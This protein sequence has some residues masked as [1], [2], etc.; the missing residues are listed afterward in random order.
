MG[1]HSQAFRNA[2]HVPLQ[3]PASG[4]VVQVLTGGDSYISGWGSAAGM[5]DAPVDGKLYGRRDG[6]WGIVV[7]QSYIDAQLALKLDKT[8]YTAADVF[9]K[10]LTLD[11]VG[12]ALDAD[13]LD[14]QHGAFYLARAN[15]TGTQA[16]ST[17]TNLQSELDAKELAANKGVA[18]GYAPLD[19][20]AKIA[21]TYLPAYVDDVLE[22]ASLAAFPATGVAGVI[23]VALDTKKIYRWSGSAY[24]ELSP[25]PGSTDAVPEGSV[26]LYFTTG[27]AAAAAPVQTV[28]GR[29]GAVVITKSDL[30]L[31]QVDN[32]SDANKPIST[33][34]ANALALKAPLASPTFTGTPNA[35]TPSPGDSTT[36]LATTAFVAAAVAAVGGISPSDT[37]PA[38]DGSG[39]A[40]V[41]ALYSR[42]DHVH[43]S[44]T[45]RAPLASPT[46]TGTPAAPTAAT[47]TN[48]TQIATTAFVKNQGY[49][50]VASFDAIDCGTF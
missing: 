5:T 40:G 39:A 30:G 2:L 8:S 20:S 13:L 10:V 6:E 9:S 44:D 36:K 43:P 42:G 18:N 35:P 29:T 16:I 33:A 15:H 14:A 49:A 37:A 46:F 27:R 25:S 1:I 32:T 17:I 21:A 28:Q 48:S 47:A 24:I 4:N 45:S 7:E 23:Y 31:D 19:G 41:S 3:D 34:T 26:N 22:Y 50:T 12:S 38:M 11:G